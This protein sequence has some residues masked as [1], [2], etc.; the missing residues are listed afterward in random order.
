MLKTPNVNDTTV[1]K[2]NRQQVRTLAGSIKRAGATMV[3]KTIRNGIKITTQES[4][5]RRVNGIN[6]TMKKSVTV[7]ITIRSITA[8]YTKDRVNSPR[9]K[10]PSKSQRA[11][12]ERTGLYIIATPHKCDEPKEP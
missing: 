11:E 1:T 2:E 12:Q 5:N 3:N 7:R 6:T 10:R 4:R 8:G 9:T